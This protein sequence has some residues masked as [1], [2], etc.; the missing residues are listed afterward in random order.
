MN[1][2]KTILLLLFQTLAFACFLFSLFVLITTDDDGVFFVLF[3]API[4]MVAELISLG[5]L[6]KAGA[7]SNLNPRV[8]KSLKWLLVA[9][10]SF[11]LFVIGDSLIRYGSFE[12][13]MVVLV[14]LIAAFCY[15]GVGGVV[16]SLTN[17]YVRIS[18]VVA[19]LL[20]TLFMLCV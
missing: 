7:F 1:Q 4:A 15:L 12:F 19:T 8:K 6:Y 14:S 13:E 10:V 18:L 9:P 17:K 5:I 3:A 20:T 2:V 16:I 11:V